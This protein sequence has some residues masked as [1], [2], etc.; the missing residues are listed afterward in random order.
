MYKIV[1]GLIIS[2]ILT[3]V[4]N[5]QQIS[6][7]KILPYSNTWIFTLEG[8]VTMGFSDY[9]KSKVNGAIHGGVEYYFD[10]TRQHIFGIKVF[11]GGQRISGEDDRAA[12]STN[13]GLRS[14]LSPVFENEMYILGIAGIYSYSIEDK[15]FPFIQIGG[16]Y[17]ILL[18]PKDEN[19]IKLPGL[20]QELY[21][22]FAP[23][24]D[25]NIGA[26]ILISEKVSLSFST[27]I[28]LAGTDYIDD[29]ATGGNNDLYIT[30]LVGVSVSPFGPGDSDE[31]GVL[32]EFDACPDEKEDF[33]GFE[34][35]DG[36]PDY[37]NDS[38]GIPDVEDS[39]PLSPEDFDGFADSDGCADPDNDLDGILDIA[40]ECPDVAED[41]DGFLDEDGCPDADN[42]GDGIP[43]VIDDC[44]NQAETPNGFED[45]DGCPDQFDIVSVKRITIFA[46]EIF[47]SSTSTIKP[48]GVERL[49]EVFETINFERDSKWRIE[50]HMDSQGSEQF[51][52]RISFDRAEAVK[53]YLVSQGIAAERFT[54]YGM[55]DDF[56]IGDNKNPEGR[57]KNRRIEI[58][59]E[60]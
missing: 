38:D 7:D 50:G 13:D 24:F 29:I 46:E 45:Q 30:S 11:G 49:N 43:D 40:D 60:F 56:P 5:G 28:H 2:L 41:I 14:P 37:D 39:C 48:Q 6:G 10:R 44:P 22:R 58:V 27:G 36:C 42:D 53:N 55:S 54:L 34:D 59:R 18:N 26:K 1:P 57:N 16:S 9:T 25:I 52:R 21:D 3:C 17:L 33:D 51:I 35:E 47:Y 32:N 12:V 31:D 15:Y 20:R 23:T 8:G 4:I 19:G